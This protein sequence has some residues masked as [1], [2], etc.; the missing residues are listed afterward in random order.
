M[1]TLNLKAITRWRQTRDEDAAPVAASQSDP[2]AFSQLYDR[3]VQPVYRYFYYRTGSVPEAEGK[4][5]SLRKW[6][7]QGVLHIDIFGAVSAGLAFIAILAIC[8][9]NSG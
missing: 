2:A 5:D 7:R 3:Y 4:V 1:T 9:Y 8:H 6:L